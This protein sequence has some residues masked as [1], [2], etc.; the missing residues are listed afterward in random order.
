[1]LDLLGQS[2]ASAEFPLAE[3]KKHMVTAPLPLIICFAILDHM[4]TPSCQ[5]VLGVAISRQREK[6]Q[7]MQQLQVGGAPLLHAAAA[8]AAAAAAVAAAAVAAAAAA[9]AATLA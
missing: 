1:M 7:G 4:P 2:D 6:L 8:A 9:A 5:A 3:F